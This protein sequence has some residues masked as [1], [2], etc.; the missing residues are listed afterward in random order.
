[1]ATITQDQYGQM[2]QKGMTDGQ[3]RQIASQKGDAID[4]SI[5]TPPSGQSNNASGNKVM[6]I[7]PAKNGG[8]PSAVTIDSQGTAQIV[9]PMKNIENAGKTVAEAGYNLVLKPF[10]DGVKAYAGLLGT[11][12]TTVDLSVLEGIDPQQKWSG[13][14]QQSM[15]KALIPL[16][17]AANID[18]KTGGTILDRVTSGA[19]DTLAGEGSALQAYMGFTGGLGRLAAV[20]LAFNSGI[21]GTGNA[22]KSIKQGS[23][24]ATTGGNIVK[25]MFGFS[26]IGPFE[27]ALGNT[28]TAR[29]ADTVVSLFAP[30]LAGHMLGKMGVKLPG[31]VEEGVEEGVVEPDERIKGKVPG[32]QEGNLFQKTWKNIQ[33]R[34]ATSL[35][36]PDPQKSIDY[37]E[38]ITKTGEQ[39]TGSVTTRGM[40]QELN[41]IVGD[42]A[43]KIRGMAQAMD[44]GKLPVNITTIINGDGTV[45]G[46]SN[47]LTA[48]LNNSGIDSNIV[49]S[50]INRV[51]DLIT[52]TKGE[53][54]TS[55]EILD[56]TRMQFNKEIPDGWFGKKEMVSTAGQTAYGKY[57]IS[58]YLKNYLGQT[59]TSGN[60]LKMISLQHV[61]LD[62]GKYLSEQ[63]LTDGYDATRGTPTRIITQLL[64]QPIKTI[65]EPFKIMA[66][67]AAQGS[68]DETT[69]NIMKGYTPDVKPQTPEKVS[70]TT[71]NVGQAKGTSFEPISQ[72]DQNAP[73]TAPSLSKNNTLSIGQIN[74]LFDEAVKTYQE[75]TQT[76]KQASLQK[77][78]DMG[79]FDTIDQA[80][81]S[82]LKS[83]EEGKK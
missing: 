63:E 57:L 13:D 82:I 34:M 42:L 52:P 14:I 47:S 27:G 40:S 7:N 80:E 37:N 77:L 44:N 4:P 18:P 24:L 19:L 51:K 60:L 28:P 29:I 36:A 50:L 74:S 33:G 10:V 46:T 67:R 17:T 43:P 8:T 69:Q 11:A 15:A 39:I 12:S 72:A 79:L 83:I 41:R 64:I 25:G 65:L 76:Q 31:T 30:L 59:D 48:T 20:N 49:E 1:M 9:N 32:S 35:G 75:G 21:F 54:N 2:I 3:I 23:D 38:Y 68:P 6:Y 45:E 5:A 22:I 62:F 78:V 16:A 53:T 55:N 58:D 61:G 71:Q 26:D 73:T 56:K 70:S 81:E 66:V